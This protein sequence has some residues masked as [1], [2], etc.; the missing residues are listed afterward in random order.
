MSARII[1]TITVVVVGASLGAALWPRTNDSLP[2]R[3]ADHAGSTVPG[4]ADAAEQRAAAELPAQQHCPVATG[5]ASGRLGGVSVRCLG[6]SES[7]DLGSA[8]QGAP[9]LVNLWASWCA[10]CREEMPILDAYADEPGAIRVVGLNVQDNPASALALM[11]ALEVSYPS[12]VDIDE[13]VQKTL[14][15]PPVLPLSFLVH[16]DGSVE[17]V[18]TPPVFT[19]PAQVRAAVDTML[20]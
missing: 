19:D 6:S 8:L 4:T 1:W 2:A 9:T 14:A 3:S 20:R 5:P 13:A 15:A 16:R 11:A 18:A 10:P 12:F 7:I 17:R